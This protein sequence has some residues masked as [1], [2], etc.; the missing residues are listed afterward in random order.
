MEMVLTVYMLKVSLQ[1]L[2]LLLYLL[3][4]EIIMDR[5]IDKLSL[6]IEGGL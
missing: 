4:L 1:M 3:V 2:H 5:H 6:E